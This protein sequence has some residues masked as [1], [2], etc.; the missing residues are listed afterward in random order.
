MSRPLVRR[1]DR[2]IALEFL[3][4]RHRAFV[5]SDLNGLNG[6]FKKPAKCVGKL[7]LSRRPAFCFK[8]LG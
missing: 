7:H 6:H 1:F 2:P 8:D 3:S 5:R 4:F